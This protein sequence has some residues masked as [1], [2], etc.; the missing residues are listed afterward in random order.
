L[1][2]KKHTVHESP[3]DLIATSIWISVATVLVRHPPSTL[4]VEMPALAV[5]IAVSLMS[6]AKIAKEGGGLGLKTPAGR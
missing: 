2:S 6:V 4:L 3:R 1:S 5:S